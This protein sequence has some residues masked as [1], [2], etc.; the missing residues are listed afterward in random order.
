MGMLITTC[1][2]PT[3]SSFF[4]ANI[5]AFCSSRNNYFSKPSHCTYFVKRNICDWIAQLAVEDV[6]FG[7]SYSHNKNQNPLD[8]S[9]IWSCLHKTWNVIGANI[10]YVMYIKIQQKF[11]S[12]GT[13]VSRDRKSRCYTIHHTNRLSFDCN[14]W[15]KKP[16]ILLFTDLVE[17][18]ELLEED[19][20]LTI[21][22]LTRQ[23]SKFNPL[24][25]LFACLRYQLNHLRQVFYSKQLAI[26]ILEAIVVGLCKTTPSLEVTV[27]INGMYCFQIPNNTI[28]KRKQWLSF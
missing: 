7:F 28:I 26:T 19:V 24:F 9:T 27:G 10:L 11:F 16:L 5:E 15:F 14:G 4:I 1:L 20:Q 13:I 22:T 8:A 21:K 3:W 17:A 2:W 25:Y 12:K 18:R 23:S 6:H